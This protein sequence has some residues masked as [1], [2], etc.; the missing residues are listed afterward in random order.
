MVVFTCNNCGDS[1]NKPKVEKHIQ[2][3]C[4]RKNFAVSFCCVDC[5]K[6]FNYETVRD[7]CQCVTE[8]QR[9]SAKGYV[10]KPSAEKGK[11][12]QAGWVDIV[13]S[14]MN[15]KDL[16]NEQRQFLNI[17]AKFD[18]VPR[19]KNKFQNFCFSTAP[20]YRRKGYIVDQVFDMIEAE[21][22]AQLP[23]N[24]NEK[25]VD[26]KS[27][28]LVK[29]DSIQEESQEIKNKITI[30]NDEIINNLNG[31]NETEETPKKKK[32][33]SKK[34]FDTVNNETE[35]KLDGN[36]EPQSTKKKNTA[37]EA[38]LNSAKK[39]K[40]NKI[41][42][43]NIENSE[44]I[45]D[46][47]EIKK[48]KIIDSETFVTPNSN[49]SSEETPKKKKKSKKSVDA[50]ICETETKSD[51][52]QQSTKKKN[53][54]KINS[55]T[56]DNLKVKEDTAE[57]QPSSAKKSKKNKSDIEITNDKTNNVDFKN[58]D[59]ICNENCVA[60]KENGILQEKSESV[61][62]KKEKKEMK[63]KMKYQHELETVT[64]GVI[65]SDKEPI[66]KKKKRKLNN[67]E[68]NEE[69]K[70]KMLKTED[71]PQ[72]PELQSGRKFEWNEAINQVLQAKKNKPISLSKVMKRVLSEFHFLNEAKKSESDLEKIFLKKIKKMKNVKIENDKVQLVEC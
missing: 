44:S 23:Q 1:V 52:E 2:Y 46:P 17:I 65:E 33:K 24:S 64:N 26:N 71:V 62:S 50:V 49:F 35:S 39:S 8:D 66:S 20:A 54:L 6:D 3:E 32:K 25:P 47:Q 31:N 51:V 14:V 34:S 63:K 41:N 72:V 42:T 45:Q 11:R 60:N 43:E 68:E 4:K 28:N 55:G 16:P 67:N 18:N 9:Y 7:H 30:E 53:I 61:M 36:A 70:Q 10:P 48:K 27:G 21:Y 13:Q 5:L 29:N 40:K 58:D 22:K 15:N 37:E 69:P 57:A 59:N 19:K 38:Q 56:E 12:K